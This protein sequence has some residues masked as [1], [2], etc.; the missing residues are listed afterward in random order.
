MKSFVVCQP[1]VLIPPRPTF[2]PIKMIIMPT[3]TTSE[4]SSLMFFISMFL[5]LPHE[6][7]LLISTRSILI[8]I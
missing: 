7:N 4:F 2:N 3:I 6:G 8:K 5:S 1:S